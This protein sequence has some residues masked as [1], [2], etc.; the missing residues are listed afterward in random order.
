MIDKAGAGGSY[1]CVTGDCMQ[2]EALVL[3]LTTGTTSKGIRGARR[4]KRRTG[5]GSR[6]PPRRSTPPSNYTQIET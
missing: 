3:A 4:A 1:A 2:A 5:E 6:D